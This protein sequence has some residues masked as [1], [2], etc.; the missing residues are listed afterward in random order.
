MKRL[1]TTLLTIGFASSL[2]AQGIE[3]FQGSWE[4]AVKKASKEKKH[5][6]VDCYTT[7]CGPCKKMDAQVFPLDEVGTFMNKRF[8]S[9]KL[10]MEKEGDGKDM[11]TR[12]NIRSYPTYLFFSPTGQALHRDGSSMPKEKFLALAEAAL[13]PN[14]QYYTIK[15][16][17]EAHKED[18]EWLL[19]FALATTNAH[20]PTDDIV[21]QYASL[22]LEED[23]KM[24]HNW[25]RLVGVQVPFDS[26]IYSSAV[27]NQNELRQTLEDP[28]YMDFFLSY[29]ED[30][31]VRKHAFYSKT[32]ADLQPHFETITR[33]LPSDEAA[34]LVARLHAEWYKH[35]QPEDAWDKVV[36]YLDNFCKSSQELN[37]AAWDMVE[38]E[39]TDPAK[40]A[41]GLS[42]VNR[43]IELDRGYGNLD[44]KAW[45]LYRMGK[46]TEAET[47]ANEAIDEAKRNDQTFSGTIELIE[48]IHG[49]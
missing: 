43:S 39:T 5:I 10:D 14:T 30:A 37:G 40:L 48:L 15:S 34:R 28:R 12:M 23:W 19:N 32:E 2:S 24:P 9:V 4:Q 33:V 29:P 17:Y 42:W 8:I 46:T 44:T 31:F 25:H 38:D 16:K 3:F 13:D 20:M 18:P 7:W 6:F 49:S 41:K 22:T 1:I 47:V 27:R 21:Q 26:P 11:A 45:L 36:V 35:H